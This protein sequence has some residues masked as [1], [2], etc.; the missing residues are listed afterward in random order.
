MLSS[1]SLQFFAHESIVGALLSG[2]FRCFRLLLGAFTF[3]FTVNQTPQ[4]EVFLSGKGESLHGIASLLAQRQCHC[5]TLRKFLHG[6]FEN[7]R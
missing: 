2:L 5:G 6:A 1:K 4:R 7:N 3:T